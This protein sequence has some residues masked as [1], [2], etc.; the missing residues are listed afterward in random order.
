[1]RTCWLLWGT[2]CLLWLQRWGRTHMRPSLR[3]SM[4]RRSSSG[5]AAAS[6]TAS[7]PLEWVSYLCAPSLNILY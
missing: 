5:C 4:L 2:P 6:L 7:V 3:S 1:M